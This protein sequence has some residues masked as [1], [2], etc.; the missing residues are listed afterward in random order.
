MSDKRHSAGDPLPTRRGDERGLYR[1]PRL[2]RWGALT[3]VTLKTGPSQD[4]N[5]NMKQGLG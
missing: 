3:E 2:R 1:P 4:M 5:Q